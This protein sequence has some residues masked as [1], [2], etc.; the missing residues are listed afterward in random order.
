MSELLS[1]LLP[2]HNTHNSLVRMATDLL[3]VLPEL[4]S[5]FELIVIDDA[6][7]DVSGEAAHDLAIRF[8]QVRAVRNASR[9]GRAGLTRVGLSQARGELLL[10]CDEGCQLDLRDLH[11][12]WR[13][14][15]DYDA[16]L[17]WPADANRPTEESWAHRVRAWRMRISQQRPAV[18]QL[19]G[20]QLF[21]RKS[22]EMLRNL[23]VDRYE[24]LTDLTRM[25]QTWQVVEVRTNR[26]PLDTT[27]QP[28]QRL[29]VDAQNQSQ[30]VA[31]PQAKRFRMLRDFALGE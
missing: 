22:L 26:Y 9:L 10:V 11:K 1:V 17:A 19:P 12:L 14:R 7:T 31:G 15:R 23:P 20:Y 6:S 29:R 30:P 4:T 5:R 25:G 13:T 2:V 27:P 18:A 28:G 3:E 21:G 8:P 16:V 24:L